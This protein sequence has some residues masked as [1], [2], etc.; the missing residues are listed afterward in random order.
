M[1]RAFFYP[2][3]ICKMALNFVMPIL[4]MTPVT[5]INSTNHQGSPLMTNPDSLIHITHFDQVAIVTLNRA[6]KRNAINDAMR[7]AL[8][9]AL[10]AVNADDAVG[11]VV[12]IGAGSSFCAGGDIGGM[13]ERLEAPRGKVGFNGWKRQKQTHRL[14][15][16]IYHM[17]KP[18]TA[19]VNGAVIFNYAEDR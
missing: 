1:T 12:L 7:N 5:A 6:E 9:D 10:Q 4:N 8:I 15:S 3:L 19:A 13:R 17:G 2:N 18:V 14:I 16:T 11:A